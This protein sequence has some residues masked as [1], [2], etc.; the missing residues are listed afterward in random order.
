M[1]PTDNLAAQIAREA[2][3]ERRYAL[4]K[5]RAVPSLPGI[6]ADAPSPLPPF[7]PPEL[8]TLASEASVCEETHSGIA[9]A[10]PSLMPL[11][12][13]AELRGAGAV[14]LT[15]YSPRRQQLVQVPSPSPTLRSQPQRT[16]TG[17]LTS[18]PDRELTPG[19]GS[20]E[21]DARRSMTSILSSSPA[22]GPQAHFRSRTP[23][24]SGHL[25]TFAG[26]DPIHLYPNANSHRDIRPQPANSP[27]TFRRGKSHA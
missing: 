5:G 23:R 2:E 11:E 13:G 27:T 18:I 8:V 10:S 21:P 6:S 14:F 20:Y 9:A 26:A 15:K 12:F 4:E 25:H 24:F 7:R 17:A 19:P 22:D 1:S 3:E 16:P